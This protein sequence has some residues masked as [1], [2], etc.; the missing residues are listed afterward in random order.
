MSDVRYYE[1]GTSRKAA[2]VLPWPA[3]HAIDQ[4]ASLRTIM[5]SRRA[6]E[7]TRS[8]WA[9]LISFLDPDNL[10]MPFEISFGRETSPGRPAR[11]LRGRGIVALWLPNNVSLL[12]PLT[13]VLLSLAGAP[14]IGKTGSRSGDLSGAWMAYALEHLPA[15]S[16]REFLTE[17]FEIESFSRTDSRNA[18]M[19]SSAAVRIVFGTD[20]AADSIHALPHPSDSIGISFTDR[21][22]RAWLESGAWKDPDIQTLTR[23]FGVYGQAGCTSP[24]KVIVVNGSRGEAEELCARALDLWNRNVRNTPEMHVAS[25]NV[26]AWQLARANGWQAT[27]AALNSAVFASGEGLPDAPG[28]WTLPFT[29]LSVEET[30][31]ELPENIQTVGHVL[32]QPE[33]ESWTRIIAASRVK[34]FVPL[35]RMHHFEPVWDGRNFWRDLFEEVELRA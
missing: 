7:F 35:G 11:I 15:G 24:R 18:E 34:R 31:A 14:V 10:R 33:S 22:S 30:V 3:E 27:R 6:P 16:L 26:L 32:R 23:I 4:W 29:S 19:A 25:R 9:Y 28:D 20:L 13:L 8:E 12:G 5:V 2:V 21:Q 17:K 1:D